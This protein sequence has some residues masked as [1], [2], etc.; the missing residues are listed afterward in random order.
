MRIGPIVAVLGALAYAFL[1]VLAAN[2]VTSLV[3]PLTVPLVLMVLIAGGLALQRFMG[4]E[5][6]RSRYRDTGSDTDEES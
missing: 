4:I 1:W 2:G 3:G 5:P 6:H